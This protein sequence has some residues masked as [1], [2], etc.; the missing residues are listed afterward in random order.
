MQLIREKIQPV[1]Q[2]KGEFL[3]GRNLTPESKAPIQTDLQHSFF[4]KTLYNLLPVYSQL[5]SVCFE[6][7]K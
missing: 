5:L 3:I 6:S 2:S 7:E 1:F 4:E